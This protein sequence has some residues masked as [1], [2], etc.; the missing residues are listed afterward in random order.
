MVSTFVVSSIGVGFK[1][2]SKDY[3]SH[4]KIIPM[5]QSSN[6]ISTARR[7]NGGNSLDFTTYAE[8][9]GSVFFLNQMSHKTHIRQNISM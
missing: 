6:K 3:S 7:E 8:W 1:A 5:R 4:Y 9:I 2:T